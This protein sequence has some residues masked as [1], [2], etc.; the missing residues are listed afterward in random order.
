MVDLVT[1]SFSGA[2][3][4]LLVALLQQLATWRG[5][6]D[7]F[8]LIV[9]LFVTLLWSTTQAYFLSNNVISSPFLNLIEIT[10]DIVW[11]ALL[12]HLLVPV[13]DS[14]KK[15]YFEIRIA[16][17]LGSL[18]LLLF[19]LANILTHELI[20]ELSL[21]TY[22]SKL[23]TASFL[24]ISVCLLTL[25]I[26]LFRT[27]EISE[28]RGLSQIIVGVFLVF[29]LDSIIYSI[30]LFTEDPS[31]LS[32]RGFASVA[33]AIL[34]M[35]GCRRKQWAN[36]VFVSQS[37]AFHFVMLVGAALFISIIGAGFLYLLGHD[38]KHSTLLQIIILL[39][40]TVFMISLY[41]SEQRLAKL[42]VFLNKHFFN[43][44]Y[45]YREEW[46]RFI[47]TLS[48]GGPGAH[49]LETVIQ[50]LGQI[51]SSDGGSLWL[52]SETGNFEAAAHCNITPPTI[53][54]ES[55][56][57]SLV[58]FL[59][60]WQ[61][62]INL[63]E[64]DSDPTLYQELT[65]PDWLKS[66]KAWLVVPLMQDIE[67]LGF[68]VIYRP[69][70]PHKINW[71]DHDLLK[72]SGRQAATHL[73]QLMAVQALVEAREFQAFSR[74]SAFVIH[75]LKN[76]VGQLSLVTTNAA[77][78]KHNPAFMEDTITTVQ[79]CVEK[80]NR[81]L[82]QM[83]QGNIIQTKV[84][85][86]N[87]TNVVQEIISKCSEQE[88]SATL[89]ATD[90]TILIVADHDRFGAVLEHLLQNA[91]EATPSDG[92]VKVRLYKKDNQAIIEIE[93]NGCGMDTGFIRDRLFRPFDSTK[94]HGGMGIGAYQ[95]RE[96]IREIN[97]D[98]QV[99][100]QPGKGSTF[101]LFLPLQERN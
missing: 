73:A 97:G 67:L 76:L 93:D 74:L 2:T 96:Y 92:W 32:L 79:H 56:D 86:I 23:N 88:P 91:Q 60:T 69:A 68:V 43:Y 52:R 16:I 72:T 70:S 83:R 62:I 77:K 49:L 20:T 82:A 24:L 53:T 3:V 9:A 61:W 84:A 4:L 85:T 80:M 6:L 47:R 65:L 90:S 25:V 19:S 55:R 39:L 8:L 11:F 71:E 46:L 100:S 26:T 29:S 34:I 28:R 1:L 35:L 75:D 33:L 64:Y 40:A 37:A 14:I 30:G 54:I 42:K 27:K 5:H 15:I 94:G 58:R 81:L 101:T 45:D 89:S 50:A 57:S 21:P 36:N 87:L 12:Y 13:G 59:Q 63:D 78:H 18:G 98:I 10:R 7:T 99:I 51:V 48:K 22:L 44:K 31:L 17:V 38:A 66:S 95:S 41:S